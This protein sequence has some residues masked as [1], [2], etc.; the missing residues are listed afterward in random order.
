MNIMT[1]RCACFVTS[2][3]KFILT[4]FFQPIE[5]RVML[6]HKACNSGLR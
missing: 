5:I 4:P 6:K 3:I 1:L 2:L